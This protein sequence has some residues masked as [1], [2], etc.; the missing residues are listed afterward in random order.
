MSELDYLLDMGFPKSLAEEALQNAGN[1]GLEAAMDWLVEHQGDVGSSQVEP[2]DVPT[3]SGHTSSEINSFKCEECSKLLRNSDEVQLHSARTGHVNFAESSDVVKPLTEEERQAQMEKL[4]V[5]LQ[6]K[7]E[8]RQTEEQ[9]IAIEREKRRREQGKHLSIAKEKF[10]EDEIRRSIEQRRREKAEDK[11]YRE[12][13]KADIAREREEKKQ[14][15]R[16]GSHH[17]EP[18]P[19]PTTHTAPVQSTASVCRLQIRLPSGPPLKC[20]FSPSETLSAVILYISQHWPDNSTEVD[21]SS[22]SVMTTFPK[23]QYTTEDLQTPLSQ[24][25]LCPS[26]VLTATRK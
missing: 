3:N 20:E 18:L 24:L 10:E 23:R 1:R 7:K 4:Q 22:I 9:K 12:K 14:R 5:I 26:A 15:E 8:Q 6:Q 19:N 25:D 16:V 2:T 17:M 21:T 11:A 13:L